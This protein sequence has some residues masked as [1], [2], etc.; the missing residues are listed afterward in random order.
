M[1]PSS[2]Y[3]DSQKQRSPVISARVGRGLYC[4]EA[5]ISVAHNTN[6]PAMLAFVI[7]IFCASATCTHA[8]TTFSNRLQQTPFGY[9]EQVCQALASAFSD[10]I[11]IPR[12]PRATMMPSV[13]ANI[14][15]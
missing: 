4:I 13:K 8:P 11:S 2:R 14:S 7:I 5:S 15:S 12:S 10:G 6:F 1:Q 3:L 9:T